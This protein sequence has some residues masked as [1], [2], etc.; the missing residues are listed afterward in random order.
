V[1]EEIMDLSHFSKS[2]G[3]ATLLFLQLP[4]AVISVL[5]SVPGQRHCL[6]GFFIN[7]RIFFG[8]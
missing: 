3:G 1:N 4:G 5:S 6:I 2:G 7:A 8:L